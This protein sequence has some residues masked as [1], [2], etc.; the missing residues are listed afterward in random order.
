MCWGLIFRLSSTT[1]RWKYN[2]IVYQVFE[3]YGTNSTPTAKVWGEGPYFIGPI[4]RYFWRTN[5]KTPSQL[6]SNSSCKA[7]LNLQWGNHQWLWGAIWHI[8]PIS[9]GGCNA[10][11]TKATAYKGGS[12]IPDSWIDPSTL[13]DL[14]W[15]EMGR[16]VWTSSLGLVAPC[17]ISYLLENIKPYISLQLNFHQ[18]APINRSG[19]QRHL[20]GPSRRSFLHML[21]WKAWSRCC[22]K[23][24]EW[25]SLRLTLWSHGHMCHLEGIS[26]TI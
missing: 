11:S 24:R 25:V 14:P 18:K 7:V 22:Y 4:S 16:G 10:T 8:M 3:Q 15:E 17:I 20:A 5:C 2:Y 9:K 21:I 26:R 13:L 6:D 1:K 19:L 12:G 23:R